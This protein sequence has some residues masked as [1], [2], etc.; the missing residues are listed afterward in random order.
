MCVCVYLD[1]LLNYVTG[2]LYLRME[3]LQIETAK[4][5][6][7]SAVFPVLC[8]TRENIFHLPQVQEFYIG[9]AA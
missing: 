6:Q 3:L 4:K 5:K 7:M 9:G 2:V 8:S 1:F